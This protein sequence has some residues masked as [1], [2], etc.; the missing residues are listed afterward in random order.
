GLFICQTA[1]ARDATAD[2]LHDIFGELQGIATDRPL[3]GEELERAK[4]SLARGYARGVETVDQVARQAAQIAL[5]GLADDH[6]DRFVPQVRALTAD[7]LREA[8]ARWI[9]PAPYVAV[10][11]GDADRIEA[12]LRALDLA[13]VRRVADPWELRDR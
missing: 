1:V 6:V 10:A 8:A 7:D 12:G 11:V 3:E 13:P 4:T 5:Y 9:W 2:A